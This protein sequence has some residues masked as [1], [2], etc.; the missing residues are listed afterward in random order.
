MISRLGRIACAGVRA[1]ALIALLAASQ[2]AV[3]PADAA[4]GS[5]PG[6]RPEGL[7]PE[8]LRSEGL[9]SEGLIGALRANGAQV[10][11][12]GSRGGLDGYFVTPADGAGYGLYVTGDGHAVAGLLYGPDGREV[13]GAQ[14]ASA[15]GRQ[16]RKAV[17]AERPDAVAATTTAHAVPEAT[18]PALSTGSRSVLFERSAAAFGFTLG[19]RGPVVLLLGDAAC[20]W[21]RSAAARLGREALAGRLQLHVVPVAVLGADAA[22]RASAIAS[23]PDP[24][25]AWFEGGGDA[26]VPLDVAIVLHAR[27]RPF[28]RIDWNVRNGLGHRPRRSPAPLANR[29]FGESNAAEAEDL[30][31]VPRGYGSTRVLRGF[32]GPGGENRY[33]EQDGTS[34]GARRGGA[35]PRPS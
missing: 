13:T 28:R 10:V 26:L 12:L 16:G 29:R 1:A 35:C 34:K 2:I 14:L 21:S 20:P 17:E 23:H 30:S 22:R 33:G 27:G 18:G 8:G 11:A 9:R 7:R 6:L 3:W 4:E 5:E 31:T 25:R 15:R 24:A 32:G 19:E